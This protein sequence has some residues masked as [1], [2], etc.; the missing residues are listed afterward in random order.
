MVL[1]LS[2]RWVEGEFHPRRFSSSLLEVGIASMLL[3]FVSY[4]VLQAT[5]SLFDFNRFWGVFLHGSLAGL[6]GI[7]STVFFLYIRRNKELSEIGEAIT[8]KFWRKEVL[9]VEQEHL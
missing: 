3:G 5:D 4:G 2:L 8:R 1:G 6:A 7:A 9:G